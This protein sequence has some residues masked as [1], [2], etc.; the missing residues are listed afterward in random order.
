MSFQGVALVSWGLK[1]MRVTL[2]IIC[3]IQGERCLAGCNVFV[4]HLVC[5]AHSLLACRCLSLLL[6][7]YCVFAIY[8]FYACVPSPPSIL[9]V[10]SFR[11]Y[12]NLHILL[13]RWRRIRVT[14]STHPP[15]YLNPFS[16]RILYIHRSFPCCCSLC[17]KIRNLLWLVLNHIQNNSIWY[18]TTPV[19]YVGSNNWITQCRW[20]RITVYQT[21]SE[22]NWKHIHHPLYLPV[23]ASISNPHIYH[24]TETVKDAL[25]Q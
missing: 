14:P 23:F 10:N 18:D 9:H 17:L 8:G 25:C 6:L 13:L 12:Q 24:Q 4:F 16:L 22:L 2:L 7:I 19:R 15:L 11:C 1:P 3:Q 21:M 20:G 5:S